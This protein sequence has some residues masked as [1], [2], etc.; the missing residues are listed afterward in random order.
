MA[1][2]QLVTEIRRFIYGA[3]QVVLWLFTIPITNKVIPL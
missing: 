2:P 1:M 3:K